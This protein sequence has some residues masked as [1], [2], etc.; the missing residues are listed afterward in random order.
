[1]WLCRRGDG[2]WVDGVCVWECGEGVCGMW[3]VARVGSGGVGM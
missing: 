1:V 2:A 3:G